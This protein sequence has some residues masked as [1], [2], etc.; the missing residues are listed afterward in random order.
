MV[1]EREAQ[2]VPEYE[3]ILVVCVDEECGVDY[4]GGGV[5]EYCVWDGV[6]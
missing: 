6:V 3:A 4:S 1:L 5:F 2:E